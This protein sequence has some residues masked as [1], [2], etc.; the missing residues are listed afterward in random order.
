MGPL[1]SKLIDDQVKLN[2]CPHQVDGGP[3]CVR[4]FDPR[5]CKLSGEDLREC[6]EKAIKQEI[7]Q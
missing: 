6:W 7:E 3:D 4:G 5:G 2:R 1:L